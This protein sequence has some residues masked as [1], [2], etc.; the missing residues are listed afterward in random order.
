MLFELRYRQ[1]TAMSRLKMSVRAEVG[2]EQ[3]HNLNHPEKMML[4]WRGFCEGL[5]VGVFSPIRRQHSQWH[6]RRV[7]AKFI[8]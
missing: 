3:A 2:S 7:T 1:I 4:R 5:S 6:V 8:S